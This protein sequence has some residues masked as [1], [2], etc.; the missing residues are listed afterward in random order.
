[1]VTYELLALMLV[2]HKFHS[3]GFEYVPLSKFGFL[4]EWVELTEIFCH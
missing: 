4:G 3:D 1:M 2:Q